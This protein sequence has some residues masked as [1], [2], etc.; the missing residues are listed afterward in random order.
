EQLFVDAFF[1]SD[2]SKKFFNHRPKEE[3]EQIREN[4]IPIF[5]KFQL[6]HHQ[7]YLRRRSRLPL[8]F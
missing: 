4:L 2:F 7:F 1:Q 6:N 5:E 8:S 3:M